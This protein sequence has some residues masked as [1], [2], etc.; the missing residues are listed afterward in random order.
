[1][2]NNFEINIFRSARRKKIELIVCNGKLILKT[3]LRTTQGTIESILEKNQTWI[4]KKVEEQRLNPS[5]S[6]REYKEGEN[7]LY[8]GKTYSLTVITEALTPLEPELVGESLRVYI[9]K[10]IK[11][12]SQYLKK[13]I[14]NWY[15]SKAENILIEKT[16]TFSKMI[17]VNP[18]N[19]NIKSFKAQWG[20][21]SHQGLIQYNW[22]L[23]LAPHDIIDYVVIHELCHLI[24]HNHSKDFW[25]CVA[26][27]LPHYKEKRSWLKKNGHMLF[28]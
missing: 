4:Q 26:R 21:C 18:S 1:M 8:L 3:P 7:F 13:T 5:A 14:Q 27:Y 16:L 22:R 6:P 23:L 12:H 9:P 19:V 20:N 25:L 10:R 11:N 24:H 2:A 15:M 28:I 17:G